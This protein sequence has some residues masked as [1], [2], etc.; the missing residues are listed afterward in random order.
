MPH[1]VQEDSRSTQASPS[2]RKIVLTLVLVTVGMFGF[3]YAML[4]LYSVLCKVT[5]LGGRSVQ[6]AK[7]NSA[8][9]V[10]DREIKI[11]FLATTNSGLPWVFQPLV[12]SKAVRLGEMS[13]AMYSAMNLTNEVTLG[14]ATYNVMPPEASLY[15]VK[16]ECFC[17]SEQLLTAQQTRQLPVH[18]FISPDLPERISEITLSYTF[19]RDNDANALALAL[20]SATGQN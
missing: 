6:V 11:R 20:A 4:P 12:N 9:A 13:D 2:N 18:F 8:V 7:D 19:Y 10:S 1:P 17:F 3:G 16:T 14:H 5:G 15:F